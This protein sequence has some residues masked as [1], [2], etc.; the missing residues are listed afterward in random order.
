MA[1]GSGGQGSLEFL[2][3]Y[4]WALLIIMVALVVMWQWGMFSIGEKV[5]PSS[6]GFW[7]LIIQQGNEFKL[8]QTGSFEASILNN[9]GANVTLLYYNATI[10]DHVEEWT[11]PGPC[12]AVIEPGVN[13]VI[14]LSSPEW[15]GRPGSRFE[16][17][18]I[19]QYQD[20]RTG[21]NIYQSSGTLWGSVEV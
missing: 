4:G 8:D 16:G 14:A 10:F 13:R 17:Q 2:M 11:C 1:S 19:V 3:T 7:G 18:L 5:E 9:V 21:A 15:G 6:F 20:V 12:A